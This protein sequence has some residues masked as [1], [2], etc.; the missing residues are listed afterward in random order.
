[1]VARPAFSDSTIDRLKEISHWVSSVLD[2]DQLLE[3][4]I[5]TATKMMQAKASSLLL[6]DAKA[7]K[8]YFKVAIGDEKR[9]SQKI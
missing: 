1:M 3:L 8:L 9:G 6:L 4:I 7:R 5:D 2:L